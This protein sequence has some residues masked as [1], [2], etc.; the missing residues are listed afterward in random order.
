MPTED[1]RDAFFSVILERARKDPDLIVVTND[2]D[3]FALREIR[4]KFP[5]QFVDVGVAEQN[6]FNVAAGLASTGKRV[7]VFGIS[8]FLAF[9]GYE[10]LR[11]NIG[12]MNLPVIVV[13]IGT[14]FS[15][16]YDG[17]THFGVD[18]FAV[19]KTIPE[20]TVHNPGDVTAARHT[21]KL[22][23]QSEGP[24]FVRL[25]KGKYPDLRAS[26]SEGAG[27]VQHFA[28]GADQ[29]IC[30]GSLTPVAARVV[31]RLRNDGLDLGLIEAF[32]IKPLSQ[33]LIAK[34]SEAE[35][36]FVVEEQSAQ[37]G[38][39]AD[40]AYVFRESPTVVLEVGRGIEL[41]SQ[42]HGYGSREWHLSNEH[43]SEEN[44]ESQ[45]RRR[46]GGQPGSLEPDWTGYEE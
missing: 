6:M 35:R 42:H 22:S 3:V 9:R 43:L 39:C 29:V 4:K 14:G 36:L 37:G 15:F 23:L 16:S 17:P 31:Q 46:L 41:S 20:L 18:D 24:V 5:A 38:L 30:T 11:V 32:T 7:I 33:S 45:L 13:G 19:L 8:S 2:M 44:I 40:L 26:I 34:L 21:A 27:F 1:I 10:Q 25:D 12:S 28:S